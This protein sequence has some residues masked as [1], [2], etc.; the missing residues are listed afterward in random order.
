MDKDTPNNTKRKLVLAALNLFAKEGINAVSMRT[1][2]TEA[3]AKN[4]SAVHYHFGNKVGII[5]AVIDLIRK[6]HMSFLLPALDQL[7]Q[8]ARDNELNIRILYSAFVDAYLSLAVNEE[9]GADAIHFF[10]RILSDI[11]PDLQDL[12]NSDPYKINGRTRA[13]LG[14]ALPDIPADVRTSRLLTSNFLLIHGISRSAASENIWGEATAKERQTNLDRFLDYLIGG[15]S[16]PVTS[17]ADASEADSTR[18]K[19]TE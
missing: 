3:G 8:K 15:M 16:A 18:L 12:I 6:E 7:E 5:S 2:N 19:A 9:F 10:S 14:A 11:N 17:E 1:I 4:A 13:L